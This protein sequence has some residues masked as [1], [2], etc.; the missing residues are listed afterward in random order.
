MS[1]TDTVICLGNHITLTGLFASIGNTGVTWTLGNGDSIK[2]VNP[3]KFGYTTTGTFTVTAEAL[4]RVCPNPWI[5]RTVTVIPAPTMSLGGDTAI[6]KGGVA[7][8]LKD[9]INA[10]NPA[11]RWLWRT[12]ATSS[13]IAVTEAGVYSATVTVNGC[14]NSGTVKVSNDCYMNVP[15]VFTPNGDGINDYFYPRQLLTR[16]LISFKMEIYN[17]WGNLIFE[18]NSLDGSGWDGKL[19]NMDQPVGVYVY[20]IDATFKDGQ[21]EHHQGNVTLLR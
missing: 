10:P 4:Y 19:N 3:L 9:E 13:A 1:I 17:R 15:N 12:G 14:S 5:S 20:M 21:K 8:V 16:G 7:L 6:C 18:T 2:D 11:A